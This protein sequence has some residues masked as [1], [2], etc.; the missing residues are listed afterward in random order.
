MTLYL[1]KLEKRSNEVIWLQRLVY[2]MHLIGTNAPEGCR[3]SEWTPAP[4]VSTGILPAPLEGADQ[5]ASDSASQGFLRFSHW[6]TIVIKRI[7]EKPFA[8]ANHQNL[9]P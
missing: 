9:G 3:N 4:L 2:S 5:K 7:L 6:N 1:R 8:V